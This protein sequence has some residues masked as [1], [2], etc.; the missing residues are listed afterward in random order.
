MDITQVKKSSETGPS[1]IAFHW[2]TS[3]PI[4][5]VI[6][7]TRCLHF[8]RRFPASEYICD[9]FSMTLSRIQTVENYAN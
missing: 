5:L 9:H 2:S 3:C 4:R 7:L 8:K 1:Y 6:F